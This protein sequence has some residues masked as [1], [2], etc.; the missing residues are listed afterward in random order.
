MSGFTEWAYAYALTQLIEVPVY[1]VAARKLPAPRRWLYALGASTLTHP[2]LWFLF[3]WPAPPVMMSD[4][5]TVFL[6][7]EGWVVIAEACWGRYLQVSR[8]WR[9]SI[10][11]NGISMLTGLVLSYTVER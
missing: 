3:P 8:P 4:Y 7:G 11:A 9:W 6:C 2:V 10:L 5:V 1:L